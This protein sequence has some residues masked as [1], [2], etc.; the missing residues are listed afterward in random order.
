MK[1]TYWQAVQRN[2]STRVERSSSGYGM[3]VSIP[4]SKGVVN[5]ITR[6]AK[7]AISTGGNLLGDVDHFKYLG[8]IL[9][10]DV[11][12]TQEIKARIAKEIAAMTRLHPILQSK[13]ISL[14]VNIRLYRPIAIFIFL[15]RCDSWTTTAETERR[16]QSFEMKCLRK[17]FGISCQ[18]RRINKS[19]HQEVESTCGRR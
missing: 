1:S 12:S 11:K 4:K 17:I 7:T 16:I 18:Q 15:Y 5:S 3:K 14:Q 9:N 2:L 6:G 19:V 8:S 10:K 13:N